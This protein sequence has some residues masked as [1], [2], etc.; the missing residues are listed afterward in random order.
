MLL[1]TGTPVPLTFTLTDSAGNPVSPV[2]T[3]PVVTV[4]QPDLTTATPEVTSTGTGQFAATGPSGQPG[5]YAVSWTCA[6]AVNPGG[7][8]DSYNVRPAADIS[9]LSMAD[10]RRTLRIDD[11]SEDDFIAEFSPAV[12][13][14]V[15]WYC[16]PVIQQVVTERLPAG[17]L[18]IQL[19]KPPVTGLLNW[20][21]IPAALSTAGIAVPDPPSPMFPTRVFGVSYPLDQ[22]YADPVL[23]TVTH[24]SGLPF[25]YGEYIWQY[26]AGRPVIPDCILTGTRAILKHVFG[27]ERGGAAGSASLGAADE[28]TTQT[29]MGFA[30]PTRALEMMS[31]EKLPAAIA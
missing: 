23:G 20:T 2:A 24:T 16:G 4:T 10:A 12:T 5:H 15:E 27:M 1:Y 29:P 8:T 28:E 31:P 26:Q 14:V 9:I 6:D 17:G 25:Y 11:D 30:V 19:S 13:Q 22:L 18:V 7:L 21:T 3:Q